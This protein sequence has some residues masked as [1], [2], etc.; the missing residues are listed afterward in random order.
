[1]NAVFDSKT[2]QKL[3]GVS[4]RQIN[5][6]DA[7]GLVRPSVKPAAGTGSR[8]LYSYHDALLLLAA[9][10]LREA[11][12]SLAGIQNA[13]AL[14]R[15]NLDRIRIDRPA[16]LVVDDTGAVHL[17]ADQADVAALVAPARVTLVIG[18]SR[19]ILDLENRLALA[20]PSAQRPDHTADNTEPPVD[21]APTR[22]SG[23]HVPPTPRTGASVWG[24]DW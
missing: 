5:H 4:V 16:W 10:S 19:L 13:M 1:M 11:G 17:A 8:R 15:P 21:G 22:E 9:K 2:V 14:L 6:W 3:T 7:V 24:G 23:K 20:V 18:L 12:L